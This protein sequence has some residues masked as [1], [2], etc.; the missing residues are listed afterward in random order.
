MG[1]EV[2]Y[3]DR[4]WAGKPNEYSP[5]CW[6]AAFPF[7]CAVP[8]PKRHRPDGGHDRWLRTVVKVWWPEFWWPNNEPRRQ[9]VRVRP[10]QSLYRRTTLK[11]VPIDPRSA[12][13]PR[14]PAPRRQ[15]RRYRAVGSPPFPSPTIRMG[16]VHGIRSLVAG[17]FG[18][19]SPYRRASSKNCY[20]R[21][22]P[23]SSLKSAR[24]TWDQAAPAGG[25]Q[26]RY[27]ALD[28]SSGS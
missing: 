6:S 22:C 4:M 28:S 21:A 11:W 16:S 5:R 7:S 8:A 15:G 9:H 1:P 13:A 25:E 20:V 10:R 14:H 18:I 3:T 26:L 19:V 12:A 24:A 17:D 27:L 2:H 23:G